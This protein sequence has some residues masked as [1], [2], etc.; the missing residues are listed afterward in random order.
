MVWPIIATIAK[1]AREIQRKSMSSDKNLK[2]YRPVG[3]LLSLPPDKQKV[4][5]SIHGNTNICFW[6][7]TVSPLKR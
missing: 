5:G 4:M 6:F 3:S 2:L 7:E 1:Y